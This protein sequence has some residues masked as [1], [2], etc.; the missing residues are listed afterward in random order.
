M[1][2]FE[3]KKIIEDFK[4]QELERF[5]DKFRGYDTSNFKDVSIRV[6]NNI[7]EEYD[8]YESI[9]PQENMTLEEIVD[10]VWHFQEDKGGSWSFEAQLENDMFIWFEVSETFFD[11]DWY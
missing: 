5:Y 10:Y 2:H 9:L 1:T 3:L 11:Y 8:I 7:W 6:Y 4:L